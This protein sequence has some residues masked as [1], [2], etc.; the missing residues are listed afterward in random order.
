[1][2][3]TRWNWSFMTSPDASDQRPEAAGVG[4]AILG[5]LYM[6]LVVLALAVPIGVAADLS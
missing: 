6:M 2:L 1:M 3:E 4:V 5:S